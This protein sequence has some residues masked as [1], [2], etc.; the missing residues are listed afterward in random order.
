[1]CPCSVEGVDF[2]ALGI[3]QAWNDRQHGMLHVSTYSAS[4]SRRGEAT[5]YRVTQ[6]PDPEMVFVRCDG[7]EFTQWR[8]LDES[9]IEITTNIDDHSFQIYTGYHAASDSRDDSARGT[10][11]ARAGRVVDARASG[12]VRMQTVTSAVLNVGAGAVGCPCCPG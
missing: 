11:R 5:T 10:Q 9:S 3:A 4:S 6:L 8:K 12:T 1:M 2:P 7:D